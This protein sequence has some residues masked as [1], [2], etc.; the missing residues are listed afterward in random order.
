MCI[1]IDAQRIVA[2]CHVV[3]DKLAVIFF[4]GQ[5][6][7]W[8]SLRKNNLWHICWELFHCISLLVTH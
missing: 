5:V 3:L 1:H 2:S 6:N 4:V 7:Y 8:L